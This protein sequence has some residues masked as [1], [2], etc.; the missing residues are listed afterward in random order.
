[1][2]KI[3]E[4]DNIKVYKYKGLDIKFEIDTNVEAEFSEDFSTC[5]DGPWLVDTTLRAYYPNGESYIFGLDNDGI[6]ITELDDVYTIGINI[7]NELLN[8]IDDLKNKA[9]RSL[10]K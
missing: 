10:V 4:Y 1:M 8:I 2:T 3:I 7:D 6:P 9:E 5:I